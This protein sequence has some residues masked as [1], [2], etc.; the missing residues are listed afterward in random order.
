MVRYVDDI[1]VVWPHDIELFQPF[2]DGLN[3]LVPSINFSTEWGN[4]E[5]NSNIATLPFLDVLIHRSPMGA[6]FSVYRKPSHCHMYIHYFSHHSPSVKKGVLSGL[7]LRALRISSPEHLQ[8]EL[9]ILWAAFKRLGY[10]DFFIRGALSS[11]KTKFFA[12]PPNPVNPPTLPTSKSRL[13][14]LPYHPIFSR[15]KHHI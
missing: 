7:Y 11:A 9:D 14:I 10:P 3:Q 8:P 12:S 15:L 1:M 2:L 4:K 13:I 6:T 5:D